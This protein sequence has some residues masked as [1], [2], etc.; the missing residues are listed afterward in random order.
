MILWP[1]KLKKGYED[2]AVSDIVKKIKVG[3]GTFSTTLSP[4]RMSWKQ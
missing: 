1:E 4:R 3:Q 2:T